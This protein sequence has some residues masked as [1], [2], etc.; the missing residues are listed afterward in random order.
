MILNSK[1]AFC[2]IY[3]LQCV[4]ID[5]FF[6]YFQMETFPVEKYLLKVSN[7]DT[8]TISRWA[9][10]LLIVELHAESSKSSWMQKLMDQRSLQNP[11]KVLRRSFL[12]KY[13][14]AKNRYLFS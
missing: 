6:F 14:T 9:G 5:L 13:L 11:V 2:I 10:V 7:K 4:F 12:R 1:Y 8:G 3:V